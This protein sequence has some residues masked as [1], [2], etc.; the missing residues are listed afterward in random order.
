M[1][2]LIIEDERKPA[3]ELKQLLIKL[4]PE[5]QVLD[6]IPG[7]EDAIEWFAAN[8]MPDLIFSDIQLA[9]ATSFRI[10][11][12]VKPTCPII[13]CTAYDEYAIKAFE[14]NGIDY[15]LKPI[16]SAKLE[17]SLDKL[18]RFENMFGA[19]DTNGY[20]LVSQLIGKMK[21]SSNKTLLVHYKEKIIPLK[22]SDVAYFYYQQ[23]IVITK[24]HS[25]QQYFLAK[26][27]DELETLANPDDFFRANRQCLLSRNAI[28][29]VE[30]FFGRKLV[31]HLHTDV[32]EPIVVSKAKSGA[33]LLWLEGV[34]S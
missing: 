12:Q 24:L 2:V 30:R 31:A 3:Q 21:A 18:T 8:P 27:I 23:G 29:S 20:D 5:W 9:D 28:K 22:Y 17:K 34:N 14:T 1:K 4:R 25:G 6:I 10:F 32:P 15:L 13:F 16:D 26:T 19:A 7:A 33:F 11:E